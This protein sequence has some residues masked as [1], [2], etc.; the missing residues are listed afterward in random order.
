MREESQDV[1]EGESVETGYN[2]SPIPSASKHVAQVILF[3]AILT[4]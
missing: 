3:N 1:D 4:F 2:H